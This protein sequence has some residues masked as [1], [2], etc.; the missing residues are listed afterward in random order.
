[1]TVEAGR[2]VVVICG[3]MVSEKAIMLV[4]GVDE[5]SATWTVKLA[6]VA[7][8]AVP[9]TWPLNASPI[10]PGNAPPISVQL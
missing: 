9:E 7:V 1:L 5:L 10:P 2:V 3:A 4:R 8:F 6:T